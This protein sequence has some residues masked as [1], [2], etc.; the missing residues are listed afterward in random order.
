MCSFFS[1]SDLAAEIEELTELIEDKVKDV[2]EKCK[3]REDYAKDDIEK[4]EDKLKE[5]E[6]DAKDKNFTFSET[7]QDIKEKFRDLLT[8]QTKLEDRIDLLVTASEK[9]ESQAKASQQICELQDRANC[10]DKELYELK[11]LFQQVPAVCC[12]LSVCLL[13][14]F[15]STDLLFF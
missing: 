14:A 15:A 6:E 5:V 9:D 1:K 8:S 3:E 11:E 12:F 4:I 2:Q 10:N 13:K 7:I